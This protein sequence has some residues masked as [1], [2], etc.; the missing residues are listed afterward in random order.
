MAGI[1]HTKIVIKNNYG[2]LTMKQDKQGKIR[3]D[4]RVS[5]EL[6]TYIAKA[7]AQR[8]VTAPAFIRSLIGEHK[9]KHEQEA[10]V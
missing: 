3:Y 9:V 1:L 10:D 2:G 8:G 6:S 5:P 4:I 7:A